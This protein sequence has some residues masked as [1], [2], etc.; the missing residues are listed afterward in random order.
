M[1]LHNKKLINST[2]LSLSLMQR[3][4]KDTL[5]WK[6]I[7]STLVHED[8]KTVTLDMCHTNKCNYNCTIN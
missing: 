1:N 8:A 7:Y 5:T 6:K 4:M 2:S 3:L